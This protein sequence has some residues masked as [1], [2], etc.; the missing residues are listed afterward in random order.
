MF[1]VVI[2]DRALKDIDNLTQDVKK[3]IA[4]KLKPTFR[5]LRDINFEF[6]DGSNLSNIFRDITRQAPPVD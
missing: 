4:S 1:K 3:R 6:F 5:Y 2:T